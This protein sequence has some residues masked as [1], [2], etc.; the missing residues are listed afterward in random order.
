M[1][2]LFNNNIDI[3]SNIS[4]KYNINNDTLLE[5]TININS[6][7]IN[8]NNNITSKTN[9][10]LL[11][12]NIFN[13][14]LKVQR[15]LLES[16]NQ[17]FII[18]RIND[19]LPIKFII[20]KNENTLT[21]DIVIDKLNVSDLFKYKEK[22]LLLPDNL[23]ININSNYNFETK[24]NNGHFIFYSFYDRFLFLKILLLI[25]ILTLITI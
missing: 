12:T 5:T 3:N 6:K 9:L 10:D 17:N 22:S 18:K 11:N 19:L 4:F 25:L 2:I 24:N 15:F 21:S 7:I 8:Q 16:E 1:N 13:S 14:K 20:S 23:S